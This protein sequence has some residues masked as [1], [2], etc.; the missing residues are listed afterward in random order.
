MDL[1]LY[2]CLEPADHY[3]FSFKRDPRL[4]R[5]I[6]SYLVNQ[7][8]EIRRAYIRAS[9]YQPVRSKNPQS[10]DHGRSFQSSWYSLFPTWLEYSIV[11][12]ATIKEQKLSR[13]MV[14]ELG[15]K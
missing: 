2:I 7:Q 11:N 8:D 4:R 9:P 12:D 10:G 3:I 5:Q 14:L 13:Y 15:G 1:T 6:W